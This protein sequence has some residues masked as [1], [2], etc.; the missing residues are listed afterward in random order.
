[1]SVTTRVGR[2]EV[3]VQI[4]D[5]GPGLSEAMLGNLFEP[6]RTTKESGTGLGLPICRTIVEAHGGRLWAEN[7]PGGGAIFSF[8]LPIAG[9]DETIQPHDEIY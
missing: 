3:L 7:G 5:S 6:F 4:A 1:M 9:A 8:A 2:E